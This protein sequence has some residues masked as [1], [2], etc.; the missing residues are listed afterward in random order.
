MQGAEKDRPFHALN[1]SSVGHVLHRKKAVIAHFKGQME[2]CCNS[3]LLAKGSEQNISA[4]SILQYVMTGTPTGNGS[5]TPDGMEKA[6][7]AIRI[8]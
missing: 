5:C 6:M 1:D 2:K 8:L 4:K 7:K 3:I